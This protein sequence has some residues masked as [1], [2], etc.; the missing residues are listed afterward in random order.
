MLCES[1]L[2][3][4]LNVK[5]YRGVVCGG[6]LR[7]LRPL[8]RLVRKGA[9]RLLPHHRLLD[10][11]RGTKKTLY[12]VA[13][14]YVVVGFFLAVSAAIQGDR[15]GTFL[16]F[17]IISG[18]LA[19][20][21]L[22]R[23]VLRIG[24]RISSVGES[25]DDVAGRLARLDQR[26]VAAPPESD[27]ADRTESDHVIDLGESAPVDAALLAA[28]TL[29]RKAYPR[30]ADTMSERPPSRSG[31]AHPEGSVNEPTADGSEAGSARSTSPASEV[32]SRNLM[33]S[34]KVALRN[35]D[36]GACRSVY[37]ALVD[38]AEPQVVVRLS[39]ELETLARKNEHELRERFASRVREQ[40]YDGA[41]AV[42]REINRL[43]PDRLIAEEYAKLEPHLL[44]HRAR[45]ERESAPPLRLAH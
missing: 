30:L 45:V 37:A 1:R 40:D 9:S 4:A 7:T 36:L 11:V 38:T 44:R 2:L 43:L 19:T 15:L 33:R 35:S 34:W 13:A 25:L 22:F 6:A 17:I 5:R 14:F 16:G 27:A 12:V 10:S 32:T 31:V 24:L 3:D 23:A 39:E 26:K 8:C 28:A 18:A 41:L 21:A 20:A 29:N 42:G